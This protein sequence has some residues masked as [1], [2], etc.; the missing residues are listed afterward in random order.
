[1]EAR[2]DRYKWR[3][4]MIATT[5][6]INFGE[7]DHFLYVRISSVCADL[8][9]TVK[10]L[11]EQAYFLLVDLITEE[12]E[13]Q[14]T[15]LAEK[16][17]EYADYREMTRYAPR[18]I[19]KKHAFVVSG[20]HEEIHK[21]LTIIKDEHNFPWVLI[22]R[23]LLMAIETDLDKRDAEAWKDGEIKKLTMEE[24]R[25]RRTSHDAQSPVP[26]KAPEP[27]TY[28]VDKTK[29]RRKYEEKAAVYPQKEGFKKSKE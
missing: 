3:L 23:V 18:M 26:T 1:M 20:L 12:G 19:Q 6:D 11:I 13:T 17:N 16:Y 24:F 28:Q 21:H 4:E 7:I 29:K 22:L 10:D 8:G 27:G 2:N 9:Y 5:K 15:L 14:F 25:A